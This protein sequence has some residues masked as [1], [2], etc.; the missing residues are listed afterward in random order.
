MD[1]ECI[2]TLPEKTGVYAQAIGLGEFLLLPI[3]GR[4]EV[5]LPMANR[6][7]RQVRVKGLG[8]LYWI[9]ESFV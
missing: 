4:R 2:D 3:Y 5:F 9:N 1:F 8:G 6:T 7:A